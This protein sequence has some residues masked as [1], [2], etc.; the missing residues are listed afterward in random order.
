MSYALLCFLPKCVRLLKDRP[1]MLCVLLH[2][3]LGMRNVECRS[4]PIGRTIWVEAHSLI[5]TVSGPL[6]GQP[7]PSPP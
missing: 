1:L 7:F 4:A 3:M 2:V 6:I 5:K